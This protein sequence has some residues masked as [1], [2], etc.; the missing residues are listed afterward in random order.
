MAQRAIADGLFTLGDAPRLIGG[1][2][3]SDGRIVFPMPGGSEAELFDPIELKPEGTLWSYTIQRFRP[4]SPP[5]AGADDER[6]F[7]P[8]AL[9]YV[10][11]PGQV[12]VESRLEV[13]DVSTL[14]VGLPMRLTLQPFSVDPDGTEVLTFAFRPAA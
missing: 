13:D 7:K 9:G 10:E 5:Y 3:C 4:K 12:I 6:T 11:L 14:K 2:R 1:K 8:Y